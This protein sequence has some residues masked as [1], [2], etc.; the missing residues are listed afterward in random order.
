MQVFLSYSQKDHKSAEQL[1]FQLQKAG[2]EPWLDSWKVNPGSNWALEVGRALES[3]EAMV[4][5]LSPEYLAS[6]HSEYEIKFAIGSPNYKN[7]LIPVLLKPV[8]ELPW[9]LRRQQF[10]DATRLD[11]LSLAWKRVIRTLQKEAARDEPKEV[12]RPS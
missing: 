2:L 1:A 6:P 4:V 12:V 10:I 11:D 3:S 7:R 8:P 5:L 9:I